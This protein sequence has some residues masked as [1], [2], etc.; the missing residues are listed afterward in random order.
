[1]TTLKDK[2]SDVYVTGTP[3]E[4]RRQRSRVGDAARAAATDALAHLSAEQRLEAQ[5]Q[6]SQLLAELQHAAPR[7]RT[8]R[9]NRLR[10]ARG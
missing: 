8:E 10:S 5:L 2:N 7:G 9:R 4:G 6:H 1:V 3:P